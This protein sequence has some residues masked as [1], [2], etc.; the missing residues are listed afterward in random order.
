[1]LE[2]IGSIYFFSHLC[3]QITLVIPQPCVFK[4][5]WAV[6]VEDLAGNMHSSC[7]L[8]LLIG[9]CCAKARHSRF[10]FIIPILKI[11]LRILEGK[12]LLMKLL[13]TFSMLNFKLLEMLIQC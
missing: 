7:V 8:G 6:V 3:F 11:K 13:I 12:L 4:H 1:M 10:C 9:H 5:V 2:L